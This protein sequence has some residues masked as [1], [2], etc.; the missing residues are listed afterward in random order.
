MKKKKTFI[1][2]LV[3]LIILTTFYIRYANRI[4]TRISRD[5]EIKIPYSLEIEY[6]DNHGWFGDGTTLAKAELTDKQIKI[7]FDSSDKWRSIPFTENVEITL[8]S[9]KKSGMNYESYLAED[10][11]IP[12]IKR[13]YWMLLDRFD[14]KR[15]FTDGENLKPLLS[16]NFSIGIIDL[17][18]NMFYYIKDDI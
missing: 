10:L 12:K 5:L 16:N 9:G 4:N 11:K 13:G 7:I 3:F 17:D 14:N 6:T 18:S 1:V 15:N 2:I 8:Y